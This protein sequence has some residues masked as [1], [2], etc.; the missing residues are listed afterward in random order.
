MAVLSAANVALL[1]TKGTNLANRADIL[2]GSRLQCLDEDGTLTVG[3]GASGVQIAGGAWTTLGASEAPLTVGTFSSATGSIGVVLTRALVTAAARVYADD[4]GAN[5]FAAGSVPDLRGLVSRLLITH[6]QSDSGAFTR[7]FGAQGVLKAYQVGWTD[8]AHAGVQGLAELVGSTTTFGGNGVTAGVIGQLSTSG[9]VTI[10]S[11]HILAGVAALSNMMGTVTQTGKSVAFLAKTY[12]T[13]NWSDATARTAWGIGMYMPRGSVVQGL[14]I[15]DWVGSGA[16]G[17][18]ILFGTGLN[19]YSDGQLDIV[20]AYGENTSNLTSAYS[21]KVG[22]FRCLAVGATAALT[23]AQEMYG[24]VGQLIA[25]SVTLTHLHAGLM[26]TF[27]GNTTANVLNSAYTVGHAGVIARI[28]GHAVITATTPL[29]GFLA[30]NNAAAA[31]TGGISTAFAASSASASYPWSVGIYMPVG[32]VNQAIRIGAWVAAAALGSAIPISA[33]TDSGDTTQRNVVA[34]YGESATDLGSDIHANVGRFRHIVA[35]ATASYDINHE[36]YG[37]VGQLVCRSVEL[38]HMHAGLMGTLEANTTAVV[39]NGAYA[40][41]VAAVIARIGG[42]NLITATKPVCGFAAVHNG[43]DLAA[44]ASIAYGAM[45]V[46]TGNWTYLLGADNCDNLLYVATG[47]A[48][49]CGVKVATQL[50]GNNYPKMD[51]VIRMY[52]GGTDYYIPF[53]AAGNIDNE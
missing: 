1:N 44:G 11:T 18:A 5:L 27:E 53:Y 29:A 14:R 9:T 3:A 47:T 19:F 31:L 33:V 13:T 37:L 36:T 20:G 17:S 8:E 39:T 30:F 23:M 16:A 21:A 28:G 32:S 46:S 38:K 24:L 22:R 34:V 15:G 7:L 26:G 43:A 6:S 10:G 25:T 35:N 48:Y 42:T 51:G 40:Y 2:L 49:E 41:S 4:G 45:A 52:V 12:D 50:T